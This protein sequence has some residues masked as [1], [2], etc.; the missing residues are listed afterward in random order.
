MAGIPLPA[1]PI[2]TFS[3]RMRALSDL[4]IHS[5]NILKLQGQSDMKAK[6]KSLESQALL[7]ALLPAGST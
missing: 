4:G 3:K 1:S 2:S 7:A 6:S 5:K